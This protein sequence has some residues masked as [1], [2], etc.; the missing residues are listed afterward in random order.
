MKQGLSL[1]VSQHL[2]LTPQL[3]QSIRLL[4]LST[5]ELDQEVEHMLV[6]NPFLDREDTDIPQASHGLQ[7]AD[8]PVSVGEQIAEVAERPLDNPTSLL[9]GTS[10]SATS[11]NAEASTGEALESQIEGGGVLEESWEGDGSV[12]MSPDDGEWGGEAPARQSGSGAG[13][14]DDTA[15]AATVLPS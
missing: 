7:Q 13:G 12:D 1:R 11:D 10:S 9:S 8:A 15:T 5:L 4:Q 3:Q 14:D 6:D 2:T